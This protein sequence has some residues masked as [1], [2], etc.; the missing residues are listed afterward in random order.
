MAAASDDSSLRGILIGDLDT[1]KEFI[2]PGHF[3]IYYPNMGDDDTLTFSF[4]LENTYFPPGTPKNDD[5]VML[6]DLKFSMARVPIE[7]LDRCLSCAIAVN[8]ELVQSP[9]VPLIYDEFE[10][11]TVWMFRKTLG[12]SLRSNWPI[13]QADG[14]GVVESISLQT[15]RGLEVATMKIRK[16]ES[17]IST[18]PQTTSNNSTH[19][20]SDDKVAM[21]YRLMF[22]TG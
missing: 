20:P 2:K 9:N 11:E 3:Y 6:I 16:T 14:D 18:Q 12:T 1:A 10:R 17:D 7:Y 4:E 13:P 5:F 22:G 8:G 19:S 21:M 15:K